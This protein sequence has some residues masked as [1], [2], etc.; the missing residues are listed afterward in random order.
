[1]L[2]R[3][4]EPFILLSPTTQFLTAAGRDLLKSVGAACL[5]LDALLNFGEDGS[6]TP[7]KSSVKHLAQLSPGLEL[8]PD[9]HSSTELRSRR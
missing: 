1:L 8:P 9:E 2:A 4:N 3:L 5:G 6:L 7:V